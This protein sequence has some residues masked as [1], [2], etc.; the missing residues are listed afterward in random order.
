[1]MHYLANYSGV[2]QDRAPLLGDHEKIALPA[3][4]QDLLDEDD[5]QQLEM[6]GNDVREKQKHIKASHKQ[7]QHEAKAAAKPGKKRKAVREAEPAPETTVT[8]EGRRGQPLD[9]AESDMRKK[10]RG[11]RN[12]GSNDAGK[13][14]KLAGEITGVPE[15]ASASVSEPLASL[16]G[17]DLE[18]AGA[19]AGTPK[20]AGMP[21]PACEPEPAGEPEPAREPAG[22]PHE[23][24]GEPHEQEQSERD[25][26]INKAAALRRAVQRRQ[27]L[28]DANVRMIRG[29]PSLVDLHP[30]LGF[31]A[32]CRSRNILSAYV[33]M[34]TYHAMIFPR[35]YTV[36]PPATLGSDVCPITVCL[37]ASS[38][39]VQRCKRGA[40]ARKQAVHWLQHDIIMIYAM[41]DVFD[42]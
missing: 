11:P 30:V 34:H 35:S 15:A 1:M 3:E 7:K 2:W 8:P 32:K 25:A 19:P 17:P 28:A 37:Y 40:D 13:S 42:S 16:P 10:P 27:E 23:P 20:P 31:T 4:L 18:P 14:S 5:A 12:R 6:Q 26:A 38:F 21:E 29:I 24:A 33:W 36:C 39:Y 22:E 9:A 41:H